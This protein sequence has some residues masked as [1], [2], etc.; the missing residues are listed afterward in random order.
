MPPSPSSITISQPPPNMHVVD[1]SLHTPP[2]TLIYHRPH[3]SSTSLVPIPDQ[4]CLSALCFKSFDRH[5]P[6][7]SHALPSSNHLD[8]LL[9]VS[10]HIDLYQAPSSRISFLKQLVRAPFLVLPLSPLLNEAHRQ[11]DHGAIRQRHILADCA[12]LS[13]DPVPGQWQKC[14]TAP[15][16][17]SYSLEKSHSMTHSNLN[18]ASTTIHCSTTPALS[19]TCNK[20][21]SSLAMSTPPTSHIPKSPPTPL[22]PQPTSGLATRHSKLTKEVLDIFYSDIRRLDPLRPQARK[23][24]TTPHRV[25]RQRQA[26]RPKAQPPPPMA[27]PTQTH[28]ITFHTKGSGSHLGLG[29]VQRL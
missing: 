18:W 22:P 17:S 15:A 27:H 24:L 16:T 19:A 21:A 14:T 1:P 8:I 12:S 11:I 10:H 13:L 3:H 6:S 25:C 7:L 9:T 28:S 23:H 29:S 26:L 2:D 5:I 4:H 20:L